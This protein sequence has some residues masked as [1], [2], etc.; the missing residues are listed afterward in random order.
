MKCVST[1]LSMLENN[2][3]QKANLEL[4]FYFHCKSI[5]SIRVVIVDGALMVLT[6]GLAHHGRIGNGKKDVCWLYM[7]QHA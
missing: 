4:I 5:P 1:E 6:C 3:S 2:W 7:I